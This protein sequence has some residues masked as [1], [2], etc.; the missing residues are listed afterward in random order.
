M[1]IGSLV[2]KAFNYGRRALKLAPD[3]LLGT[4]ADTVGAAAR[5][6]KGSIFKKAKAGIKALESEVKA[7]PTKGGFFGRLWKDIKTTPAALR[8]GAKRGAVAARAAGK[9]TLW[10]GFKG[11][12]KGIGKKMPMIGALITVAVEAPN[13]YKAFKEGGFKAGMKELGGAGVELGCMAAGT[14]IGATVGGPVGA[15]VGG[16]IGGIVGC[17]VRGDTYSEKKA[18][19]EAQA[20]LPKYSE[21]DVAALK[22]YGFTD[23]EIEQLRQNGYT[24]EDIAKAIAEEQAAGEKDGNP[25]V[26]PSD[27]T[28]VVRPTVVQPT[29]TQ[30][31]ELKA[32][33]A[34][35]EKQFQQYTQGGYNSYNPINYQTPGMYNFGFPLGYNSYSNPFGTF[36]SNPFAMNPGI[37]GS[38]FANNNQP[39]VFKY[40]GQ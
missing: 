27:N 37:G 18:E 14:A 26:A 32:E 5:A 39:Y 34:A 4:G 31:D 33:I 19:A 20:K 38:L 22:E 2:C 21:E 40:M 17:F 24:M 6:T 16:I 25:Y 8:M 12:L 11:V 30:L 7:N 28:R 36:G 15:L 1:G 10:G 3:L 35:L 29:Q 23:E 13:I 9:S